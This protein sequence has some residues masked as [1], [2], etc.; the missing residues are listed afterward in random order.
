MA[1]SESDDQNDSRQG[2]CSCQIWFQKKVSFCSPGSS[3]RNENDND[4]RVVADQTE[5]E[6]R[7]PLI[8]NLYWKLSRIETEPEQ[9]DGDDHDHDHDDIEFLHSSEKDRAIQLGAR[10][11]RAMVDFVLSIPDKEEGVFGRFEAAPEPKLREVENRVVVGK[12][13]A[14][15]ETGAEKED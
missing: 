13:L 4:I 15:L 10:I 8:P 11:S 14:L 3:D 6:V 5:E 1:T 2:F 9:V 7:R 12:M